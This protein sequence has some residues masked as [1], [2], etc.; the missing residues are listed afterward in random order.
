MHSYLLSPLY[1]WSLFH[2][3]L[4]KVFGGCSAPPGVEAA[5]QGQQRFL[6]RF[7]LLPLQT[8]VPM[9][10]PAVFQHRGKQIPIDEVPG[11]IPLQEK[12]SLRR[13]DPGGKAN[14]VP[15]KSDAIFMEKIG[16]KR[17]RHSAGPP[18]QMTSEIVEF[19]EFHVRL[20]GGIFGSA[21]PLPGNR[22]I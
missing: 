13:I 20:R 10:L 18:G 11:G 7:R 12:R 6:C 2:A 9:N 16:V 3:P 17:H 21:R 15:G 8:P 1:A 22:R 5:D 4:H 14:P 19:A